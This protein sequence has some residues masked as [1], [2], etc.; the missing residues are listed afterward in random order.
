M[1][2]RVIL[3]RIVS[4]SF[5]LFARG[6]ESNRVPKGPSMYYVQAGTVRFDLHGK[7]SVIME[8]GGNPIPSTRHV[9]FLC[10]TK[11]QPLCAPRVSVL[12][13]FDAGAAN[14]VGATPRRSCRRPARAVDGWSHLHE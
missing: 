7:S 8:D 1:C 3:R 13:P 5:G 2:P 9:Q 6:T 4:P 12:A 11:H 10:T 14:R